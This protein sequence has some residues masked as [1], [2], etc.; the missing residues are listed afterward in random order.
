MEDNNA[1]NTYNPYTIHPFHYR[2][3]AFF[4]KNQEQQTNQKTLS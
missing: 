4:T 2:I 1:Q 3:A